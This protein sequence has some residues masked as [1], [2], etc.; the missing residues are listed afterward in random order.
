MITETVQISDLNQY[1]Y[2]PRRLYYLLFYN[3]QGMNKYLL[4]GR[5][6]HQSHSKRGG[7]IHELYCRSDKI[8]LE[9]KI[10][11]IESKGGD[12][13][14]IEK[15]RGYRYFENDV[16]QLTAYGM[17]L[18]EMSGKEIKS[19]YIYL[20]STNKREKIEFTDELIEKVLATVNA[21]KTMKPSV[22]PDFTENKRKCSKCSVISYCMPY[23][24]SILEG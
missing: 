20:Y 5:L 23:E 14:P 24:T 22:L 3:T 13:F 16:V 21:I 6:N 10:D 4:E 17:L 15:K 2:C 8:G 11:V 1:L 19:G 18:E 7:W 9:G 12:L